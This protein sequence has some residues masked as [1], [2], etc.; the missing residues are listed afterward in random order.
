MMIVNKESIS[1]AGLFC[2]LL[3]YCTLA[4]AQGYTIAPPPVWVTSVG[5]PKDNWAETSP[6][7]NGGA[8]LLVDRQWSM[9]DGQLSFYNHMATKAITSAGVE[10]V[11]G[12]SIDF[13]P[14][15]ESLTLHGVTVWRDGMAQDRLDRSRISLIQRE[16]DLER[17]LYD[18]SLTLN[19][20]LED[21]R[22]GDTVE[23]S[24]TIDGANPI[25]DGHF[26]QRLNLRWT[27]PVGR[28]YYRLLWPSD[29]TLHLRN[30]ISAIKPIKRVMGRET[31]YLW[32]KNRVPS[33]QS[34]SN[35]PSWYKPYPK[36]VMSDMAEWDEVVTW[37]LPLYEQTPV[38][39]A[40][41]E[42]IAEITQPG[43]SKQQQLLAAL[44]F[45]QEQIRYLGLEMGESSHR[46]S[47][48]D[49]VLERRYGDCKDKARLL[50][51]LLRELGIEAHPA[52]VNTHSGVYLTDTLPSQH[53]F[54][55]AMVLARLEGKN[56]WID[57]TR[58]H[59]EGDLEHLYQPD[60]DY[61]LVV[62]ETGGGL[63]KMSHENRVVHS[64]QIE[65]FFDVS[66]GVES[67]VSLRI[68]NRHERYYG[69][70]QRK[71]LAETDLE[72]LQK[73]YLNYIAGYYP[74]VEVADEMRVKESLADNRIEIAEHY[75]ILQGWEPLGDSGYLAMT[76]QP[77]LIDDHVSSMDSPKRGEPYAVTHPVS[78][79]HT[80]RIRVPEE[81]DFDQERYEINDSAFRF[82]KSVDFDGRD[83]VIDYHYQSLSD[84]VMP[85]DVPD[86]AEHLNQVYN[87]STY[88]ISMIDPA[89]GFGE[90]HF[91]A[92]DVN[93][94]LVFTTILSLVFSA[95]LAYRF[96][97]MVDPKP[98]QDGE[99][100]D[101]ALR[102]IK[103]WLILP[104]ISIFIMPFVIA[105]GMTE[106]L[107]L[108]SD[109]QW[110]LAKM[111][112]ST[113]M[114]R[115][116]LAEVILNQVMLVL[117]VFLLIM[118]LQRRRGVPRLFL[119][120]FL[121]MLAYNGFDLL[122]IQLLSIHGVE[123][124]VGEVQKLVRMTVST[125][126][127]GSYFMVSRRVKATFTRSKSGR[128]PEWVGE[129]VTQT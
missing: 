102:G 74:S 55:H 61:A 1:L 85:V 49:E 96:I 129:P 66:G 125:V 103:G 122:A 127:W 99:R 30:H 28:L 90:Y 100:P 120:F 53:S 19:L 43:M 115:L 73:S 13:D 65:E 71:S 26:S 72:S 54:D 45:V 116:I 67:P 114:A 42:V 123:V 128:E 93:W 50:I 117:S 86:H 107:Y 20:I 62:A 9:M 94:M 70:L 89:V 36:I 98:R 68:L 34:D 77:T 110:E 44:D 17:Q 121:F 47:L 84:H 118:F 101:P 57:P 33:L 12:I 112:T 24:Y 38:T 23:Y 32:L 97:Y 16:Q 3:F 15:Y 109:T 31:E 80:T 105:W 106:Y 48:P 22:P 18:G 69:D 95:L 6:G 41:L 25:F 126:I 29:R 10:S 21:V 111:Q 35:T 82:I 104:A 81:S 78:Y 11:S 27:V 75:R 5:A 92:S 87:L 40:E 58:T 64:K 2:L 8:Y 52:L 124:E 91:D 4:G 51:S 59:Q 46:P 14:V 7:S 119:G 37:A 56:Y 63:Q 76:F 83:L 39:E 113:G 79:R 60:Y 108:Y 88:Q